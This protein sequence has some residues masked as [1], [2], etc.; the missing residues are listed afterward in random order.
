VRKAD[1]ERQSE[2][3]RKRE[4]RT[5]KDSDLISEQD[6]EHRGER[7][8]EGILDAN[9]SAEKIVYHLFVFIFAE[10]SKVGA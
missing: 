2:S 3:M 10:H 8:Q 5:E 9:R 4:E 6:P 7:R 1:F